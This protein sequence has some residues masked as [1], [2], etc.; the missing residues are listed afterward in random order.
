MP[1]AEAARVLAR[2]WLDGPAPVAAVESMPLEQ[3][4]AALRTGVLDLAFVPT[5]A[6]LRDPEAFSVVPGV[7]LVGRAYASARLH[8]PAGLGPLA[9]GRKPSIGLD[10]RLAQEAVLVQII[11]KE[12]YGGHPEFVPVPPTGVG[13][14]ALD[15]YLLPADAPFPGGGIT[16]DLGRE[17]FELTTRPMVWALLA[18]LSGTVDREEARLLRDAAADLSADEIQPGVEEPAAVS[19]AAY[20]FAGLETL[21][22]QFFYHRAIEEL[23]EV[24]FVGVGDDDDGD[25][26]GDE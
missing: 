20:A 10:P 25:G 2:A 6:V 18:G 15:A 3:A 5:L 7:A 4:E 26:D 8:L 19:L 21:I 12:A 11:L 13:E 14:M 1:D 23:V 17:W 9:P 24:P 22:H 16:L